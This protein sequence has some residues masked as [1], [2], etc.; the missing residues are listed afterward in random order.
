MRAFVV[1][2]EG[3]RATDTEVLAFLRERLRSHTVP[4]RVE[5]RRA[6]PRSAIGKVLRRMLATEEQD[7]QPKE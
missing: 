6:I 2:R 3:E 4:Q 7:G 1:L 5:F